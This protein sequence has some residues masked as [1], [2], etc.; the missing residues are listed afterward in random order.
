MENDLESSEQKELHVVTEN[1]PMHFSSSSFLSPELSIATMSIDGDTVF[2]KSY[3]I[4]LGTS[5]S[6]TPRSWVIPDH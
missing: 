1:L 4:W 6:T 2:S 5:R 3:V